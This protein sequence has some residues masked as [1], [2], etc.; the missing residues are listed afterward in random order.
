MKLKLREKIVE[1]YNSSGSDSLY[2]FLR[3]RQNRLETEPPKN[4]CR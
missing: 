4:I 2:A 1:V 3:T